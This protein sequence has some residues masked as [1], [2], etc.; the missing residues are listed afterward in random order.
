M[1][2]GVIAASALSHDAPFN[3]SGKVYLFAQ[4]AGGW[5]ASG[6]EQA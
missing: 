2:G 3:Q 4:P 6:I 1:D 5:S